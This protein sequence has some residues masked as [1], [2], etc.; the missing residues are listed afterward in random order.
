MTDLAFLGIHFTHTHVLEGF[1]LAGYVV[2]WA[3]IPLVLL[4]NR[5]PVSTLNWIWVLLL[6]PWLG[7]LAYFLVGSDRMA[8]KRLNMRQEVGETV[9]KERLSQH[10]ATAGR[11]IDSLHGGERIVAKLLSGINE[12]PASV[13]TKA[14]LL[15][16][17]QMFYPALLRAVHEAKQFVHVEF[18]IFRDDAYGTALRD[19]LA[20]TARRGVQVRLLCDQMGCFGLGNAFFQPIKDAGGKFAWFRTVHPL[21]NR[22][23]FNLR[24]HRKIQIIDGR[25]VFVGGMNMGREHMG[26]DPSIGSWRDVQVQ[27][28]GQV[29]AIVQRVFADDWF[30]A[31]EEKLTD[32]SY[33]PLLQDPPNFLAQ[34]IDDGPDNPEDPIQ[35]SIVALLNAAQKRAWLTAGYF[36]PNEPL[37]TALKMCASRGV[38]VRLLIAAKSDHPY[39]VQVGRSYYEPLL[40]FGVRIFEYEKGMNHAKVA[41]FDGHWMMVGSANFDNRSMRLNFELNVLLNDGACVTQLDEVLQVDYEQNSQ[42]IRLDKFRNRHFSQRCL[43]SLFRPLAPLL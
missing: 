43:E 30:Y 22:W 19:A 34:V 39:L 16:D 3:L 15:V 10:K 31:T 42:E 35:M 17:A 28:E 20:E 41:T 6:F 38:D 25:M 11:V 40:E 2:S 37:I 12:N 29:A 7:P 5:S 33:Y 23:V 26:E 4:A 9:L 1:I 14:S 24:N 27:L 13:V 36:V 21:Q 8:R 18:Y 32:P